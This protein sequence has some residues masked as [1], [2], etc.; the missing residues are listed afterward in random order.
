MHLNKNFVIACA[1]TFHTAGAAIK[2]FCIQKTDS[3]ENILLIGMIYIFQT[4]CFVADVIHNTA[5][6]ACLETEIE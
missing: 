2:S 6:G 3:T 5:T 4:Q 1:G